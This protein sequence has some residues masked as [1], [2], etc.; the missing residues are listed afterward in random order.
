MNNIILCGFMGSG[1]SVVGRELA[2]IT[3]KRFIDTDEYIEKK[4][5]IPIKAIFAAHGEDFFRDLEFEACK[6]V[7]E[8]KNCIIST[9]GGA[10]TF[11]RNV[12]V[13]KDGGRIIFLD[14]DFETICDRIGNSTTRPLFQDK[15]KARA[16]FE[17]RRPKYLAAA[18]FTV[19]GEMSARKAALTIADMTR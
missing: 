9:G 2:K 17:E 10:V 11:E 19:D 7:S 5:G 12:E 1:K 13:L 6:E 14:A 15:E 16:L 18:D 8:L 4:Q 3:G